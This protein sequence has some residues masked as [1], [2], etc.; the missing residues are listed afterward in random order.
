MIYF[1]GTLKYVFKCIHIKRDI[2][3]AIIDI[4]NAIIGYRWEKKSP[5]PQATHG[6]G[7]FGSELFTSYSIHRILTWT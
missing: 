6:Q 7:V 4:L 5:P 2:S 3:Q 1:K